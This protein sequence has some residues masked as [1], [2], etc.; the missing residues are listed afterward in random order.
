MTMIMN[1]PHLGLINVPPYFCL[2]AMETTKN[3]IRNLYQ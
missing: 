3:R 2:T 1:T